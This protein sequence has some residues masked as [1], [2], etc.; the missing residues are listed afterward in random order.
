MFKWQNI[1]FYGVIWLTVSD[2]DVTLVI[3][4]KIWAPRLLKG[5]IKVNRL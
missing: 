4:G 5:Y 3:K 2:E 1:K